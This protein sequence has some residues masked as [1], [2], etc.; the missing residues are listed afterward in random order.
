[1]HRHPYTCKL[2][3]AFD[4]A[5]TIAQQTQNMRLCPRIKASHHACAT[6]HNTHMTCARVSTPGTAAAPWWRRRKGVGGAQ[7]STVRAP[8]SGTSCSTKRAP[9]RTAP[10]AHMHICIHAHRYSI[11]LCALHAHTAPFAGSVHVGK[12]LT[13]RAESCNQQSGLSCVQHV[14][15]ST[16]SR[17][18]AAHGSWSMLSAPLCME[19]AASSGGRLSYGRHARGH[20][21][22][23]HTVIRSSYGHHTVIIRSSYG[24]HTVIIR[25]SYGHH[26]V[27]I[28]SSY[29]H[30]MVIIWSSYGHHMVIIRS[31]YGR[32]AGDIMAPVQPCPALPWLL[33]TC[34][35]HMWRSGRG[36]VTRQPSSACPRA[37]LLGAPP[38]GASAPASLA[39]LLAEQAHSRAHRHAHA[40]AAIWPY[41]LHT[42]TST[43][44][45]MH[46]R[47]YTHRQCKIAQIEMPTRSSPY[48]ARL[49]AVQAQLRCAAAGAAATIRVPAVLQCRSL[50]R[51]GGRQRDSCRPPARAEHARV[52]V[53]GTRASE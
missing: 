13:H 28:W 16:M 47:T 39:R 9:P 7:R 21:G 18:S 19:R 48:L 20:H 12:P 41:T 37:A 25:S 32:H 44:T 50:L 35:R 3:K 49:L 40:C 52:H 34:A 38:G 23:C 46:A 24:H 36:C 53:S 2:V 10:P 29:G 33:H 4:H 31:S 51:R 5:F 6:S 26:M 43:H 1:M 15:G 22:S 11:L 27:I 45:H 8:G 14:A 30:H 17:G 42:Q